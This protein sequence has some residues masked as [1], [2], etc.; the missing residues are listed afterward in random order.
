MRNH[1]EGILV[2]LRTRTGYHTEITAFGIDRAQAAI[3]IQV[4]PGNIV[5]QGP[6]FPTQL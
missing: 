5:A 3:I 2:G 6:D 4:Q 1:V